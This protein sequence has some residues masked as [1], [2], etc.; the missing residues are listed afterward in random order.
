LSQYYCRGGSYDISGGRGIFR[1]F[2]KII[3]KK[4]A[5][6]FKSDNY[7]KLPTKL[8]AFSKIHLSFE[9]HRAGEGYDL[10]DFSALFFDFSEIKLLCQ[11][12]KS[13]RIID[14]T[15]FLRKIV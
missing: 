11:N 7:R 14:Q 3:L 10:G 9:I 6:N 1:L 5:Q 2:S 8:A 15:H 12:F 13:E 4:N